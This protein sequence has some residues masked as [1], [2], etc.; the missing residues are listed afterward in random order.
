MSITFDFNS[1]LLSVNT[2]IARN[3][4]TVTYSSLAGLAGLVLAGGTFVT[5]FS[6]GA[7]NNLHSITGEETL[8]TLVDLFTVASVCDSIQSFAG[9]YMLVTGA[10]AFQK[11]YE[12][13]VATNKST[14]QLYLDLFI[15]ATFFV[16]I[17]AQVYK[18]MISLVNLNLY[19]GDGWIPVTY[20]ESDYYA[21]KGEIYSLV[22][23]WFQKIAGPN[24]LNL[25]LSIGYI[26]GF[27]YLN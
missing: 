16:G 17:F 27:G 7:L 12:G 13:D 1:I 24:K 6:H 20:H 4:E 18:F 5:V 10:P 19:T 22:W 25:L 23:Y 2:Y 9:L 8:P 14:G 11:L 21:E 3:I 15:L 26:I